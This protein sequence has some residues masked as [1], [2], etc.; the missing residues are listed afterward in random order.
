[1]SVAFKWTNQICGVE[2]LSSLPACT[3]LSCIDIK[4]PF[5]SKTQFTLR[6][7]VQSN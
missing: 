4:N 5:A 1:M 2:T 7:G 6:E 3:A